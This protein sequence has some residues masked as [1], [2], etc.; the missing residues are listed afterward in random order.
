VLYLLA[1]CR[2][3]VHHRRRNGALEP[4][5][6][7]RPGF[8]QGTSRRAAADHTAVPNTDTARGRRLGPCAA[9]GLEMVSGCCVMGSHSPV[10]I[11]RYIILVCVLLISAAPAPPPAP[12]VQSRS[13]RCWRRSLLRWTWSRAWDGRCSWSFR[14]PLTRQLVRFGNLPES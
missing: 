14:L 8:H 7:I 4:S 9:F 11:E 13:P 6:G 10:S 12:S 1:G 3:P 5:S 2:Q